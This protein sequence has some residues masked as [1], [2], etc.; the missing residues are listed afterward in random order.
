[1]HITS[2]SRQPPRLWIYLGMTS[3]GLGE[4]SRQIMSQA[5]QAGTGKRATHPGRQLHDSVG[6]PY[7]LA[8]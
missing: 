3:A 1:M 6:Y 5:R 4:L 7:F 8:R 2:L